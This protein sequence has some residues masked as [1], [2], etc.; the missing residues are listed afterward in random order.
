MFKFKALKAKKV[1][2]AA[3]VEA[4]IGEAEAALES[5]RGEV[6]EL[7]SRRAARLLDAEAAELDNLDR[8]LQLGRREVERLE[9]GLRQLRARLVE[10][11]AAER[12]AAREAERRTLQA[13]ADEL[14]AWL[15][16]RY[17]EAARTIAEGLAAL[18][19]FRERNE[20][21]RRAYGE[22]V[23]DPEHVVFEAGGSAGYSSLTRKVV[24]PIAG[25]IECHWDGGNGGRPPEL[26][27]AA[28]R[29]AA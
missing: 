21:F 13:E 24:L 9:A 17:G 19:A 12:D 10:A 18:A 23:E 29:D 25:R 26:R 16:E 4:E 2:A 7:E 6:R 14:Q 1:P 22:P 3:A 8:D 5:A 11:Q 20:A 27:V 28:G 15:R